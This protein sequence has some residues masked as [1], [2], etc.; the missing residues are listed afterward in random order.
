M[1]TAMTNRELLYFRRKLRRYQIIRRRIAY[2]IL[3]VFIVLLISFTFGTIISEA[4][5]E[6]PEVSYKYFTRYEVCKGDTLWNLAE[7]YIDYEFY[8]SIGDYI[9]EVAAINHLRNDNITAGQ[10]IVIPYYSNEY[11]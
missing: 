1:N 4:N 2:S 6:L 11:Y 8:D 10:T 5:D 7:E 9:D 3:A